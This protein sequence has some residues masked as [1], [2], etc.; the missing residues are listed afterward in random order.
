MIENE[1][2]IEVTVLLRDNRCPDINTC[3]HI[4]DVGDPEYLHMIVKDETD[5]SVLNHP[6]V[7]PKI[8]PGERLVRWPRRLGLP[9]VPPA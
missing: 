6:D 1:R 4:L 9:E 7:A 8:G 5:S 3:A 2:Q